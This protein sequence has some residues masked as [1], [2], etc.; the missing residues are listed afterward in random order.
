MRSGLGR[1]RNSFMTLAGA[2]LA[3]LLAGACSA[4]AQ[5]NVLT[6][7][8]DQSRTGAN[9]NETILTPANVNSSSFGK[10]YTVQL[11]GQVYAQPLFVSGLSIAGGT[12]DVVLVATMMNSVYAIDAPTGNILWQ[13]NFGTPINPQEVES[14]QNI[15]WNTG[16]GILSTPVIDPATDYMYFVSGNESQVNG[17][18]VYQFN[19][20]A[21]NIA[22][23]APVL[24]SPVAISATYSTADLVNPLVFSA[25][26][27]NQRPGLALANG[28]VYIAFASHEDQQPYHGWVLAYSTSTLQQ[29]A[30]FGMPAAHRVSTAMATYISRQATAPLAKRRMA[31]C[32]Q[33]TAS[34]SS[35][36]AYSYSI[37]SLPPTARLSTPAIRI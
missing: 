10:L 4:L 13:E 2:L 5:V 21:I 29:T 33:G 26:R 3:L 9:L 25:K 27:Q 36:P 20:N 17:S 12:H 35:H 1:R 22:T 14:D 18:P 30:V 31:L 37:T 32:R 11:D 24:G 6:R 34:S 16:I 8:Y 7:N 15:S 23:G 19:L 28:N